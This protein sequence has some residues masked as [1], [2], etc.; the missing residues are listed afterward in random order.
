MNAE[1]RIRLWILDN[2]IGTGDEE[3]L[4]VKQLREILTPEQIVKVL[5]V[6]GDICPYCYEGRKPCNCMNDE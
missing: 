3:P 4:L 6:V 2:T 1:E 5:E